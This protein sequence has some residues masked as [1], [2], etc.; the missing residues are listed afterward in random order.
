[1]GAEGV[2]DALVRGV[3]LPIDAVGVDLEEDRDA[4]VGADNLCHQAIFMDHASGAVAPPHA[5]VVQVGDAIGQRAKRRGLV[6]GAVRPVRVVEVPYSRST[7][8]RCRWFQIKVR[9]SSS[10]WQRTRGCAGVL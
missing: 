4:V 2:G 7:I 9:S 10:R 1:L 5:E 3:G 8:I 6:Q